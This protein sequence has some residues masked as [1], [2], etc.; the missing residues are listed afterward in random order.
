MDRVQIG[1]S[2]AKV[3]LAESGVVERAKRNLVKS[4]RAGHCTVSVPIFWPSLFGGQLFAIVG[5]SCLVGND[6]AHLSA[7]LTLA[8]D[9]VDIEPK[10]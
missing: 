3:Q 5:L 4:V 9:A 2:I 1:R 7:R 6:D 10:L 8:Y